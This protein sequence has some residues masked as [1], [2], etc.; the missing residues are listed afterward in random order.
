MLIC[1]AIDTTMTFQWPVK[2]TPRFKTIRQMPASGRGEL[3]ISLFQFPLWDFEYKLMYIPGDTSG[4][5]GGCSTATY[6]TIVNFF[7]GVQGSGSAFLFLDPYDNTVTQET[8]F[9]GV[10]DGSTTQ[11]QI[12]RQLVESGADDLIQNFVTPPDIYINGVLQTVT[13][14]YTI[15]E[16][17][18]ITFVTPPAATAGSPPGPNNITWAGQFYFACRFAKDSFDDMEEI[19]YQQWQIAQFKFSSVLF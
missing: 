13:V 4:V 14:D 1:P 6:N 12:V 8:G 18:T 3:A 16:Y 5:I 9:L 17:G 11:F 15:D 2:K 10:G 7:M 19:M